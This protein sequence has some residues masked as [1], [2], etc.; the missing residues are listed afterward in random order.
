MIE[1]ELT[2]VAVVGAEPLADGDGEA[3]LGAIDDVVGEVFACDLF[4]EPFP[5]AV[6]H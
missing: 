2:H 1:E 6:G 3:L 4:E 5:L